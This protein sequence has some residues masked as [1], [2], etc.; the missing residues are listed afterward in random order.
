MSSF[1]SMPV[2]GRM[3]VAA[4]AALLVSCSTASSDPSPAA[5]AADEGHHPLV[6]MGI[7]GATWDV[8]E[9]MIENG[10]LPNFAAL[11]ARGSSGRLISVQPFVSP[12]VWTTFATGTFPRHHN[13]LDFFYPYTGTEKRLVQSSVRRRPALWNIASAAGRRTGVV[14]YF[15][16]YPPEPINGF[17]V[18]DRAFQASVR[19]SV[20]P[21]E[22]SRVIDEIRA[23]QKAP[24]ARARLL[25]TLIPWEY[26][27]SAARDP[28]DPY[29]R[30]S[31][32]VADRIDNQSLI[33]EFHR[34][35][36]LQL[37][38][39]D[40]DLLLTYYRLV[41]HAS[42]AAWL[43]YD[44]SDFDAQPDPR[45]VDLLRD[46]I[47][48]TYRYMDEIV[49]ELSDLAGPSANIVVI[50]DHGFG[51]AT[52]PWSVGKEH[53]DKL[54][55]NHRPD[56]IWLAAG[57]D[58]EPGVVEG[59]TILDVTP[60]LLALQRLPVAS[61]FPGSVRREVLNG[62]TL[63]AS[64]PRVIESYGVRLAEAE[65]AAVDVEAEEESLGALRALGYVG[66]STSV[67]ARETETASD[68]WDVDPRLKR[69]SL[70]G[71]LMVHLLNGDLA[72][73]RALVQIIGER[74]RRLAAEV[75][76]SG[77]RDI[78]LLQE[79]LDR[80]PFAPEVEQ[81]F[82]ELANRVRAADAS[83]QKAGP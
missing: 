1:P 32:V 47:P 23:E 73:V 20:H 81:Q 28:D 7:D 26:R 39:P 50:S 76:A 79:K 55:G 53:R 48:A 43:Y 62:N 60:T 82:R 68:F 64:P 18:S 11:A 66:E 17:M 70:E 37:H 46:L 24:D 80:N 65:T 59:M 67:A 3:A 38:E 56:G 6:V 63:S 52:G 71:E 19:N 75:V 25:A 34:Q 29:H 40:L 31:R 57:P 69:R 15:V 30:V 74:D 33:D 5:P 54:T 9:P 13:V 51:S 83:G 27:R 22:L 2:L 36:T 44:S 45:D 58:I 72:S 42:H 8:M 16:T 21:A 61:D 10:E 14:G 41:D 77:L 49:G 12:V 4:L 78:H 35:V